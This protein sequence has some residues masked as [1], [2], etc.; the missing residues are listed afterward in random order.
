MGEKLMLLLYLL[1]A[2]LM[3]TLVPL[4]ALYLA[5]MGFNTI[6]ATIIVVSSIVVAGGIAVVGSGLG[7]VSSKPD[8]MD[9][10]HDEELKILRA[11]VRSMIEETDKI[12]SILEEIRDVLKGEIK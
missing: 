6:A 5:S 8:L 9:E 12:N 4:A 7:F 2:I 1:P 10:E 3:G 11:T